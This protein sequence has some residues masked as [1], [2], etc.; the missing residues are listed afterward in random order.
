MTINDNWGYSA[1]DQHW[2]SAEQLIHNLID[3]ASKGGNY[4]L[5]VGPTAEGVIPEPEVQRLAAM[6]QWLKDNGEAIYGTTASPFP[7]LAWGRSTRKGNTL[8]LHVFDWPSD[9]IL[10]VPLQN[11]VNRAY[12]LADRG[13]ALN[14]TAS[15]G[16]LQIQVPATAPDRVASVVAL[17]IEG[18]PVTAARTEGREAN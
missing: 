4:L 5:N 10:R 9:G 17:Q 13:Q 3:I 1:S 16:A 8:Y 11:K 12:L 14:C 7:S 18:E 15:G 6:G 2:K